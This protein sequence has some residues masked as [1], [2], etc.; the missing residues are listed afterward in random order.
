MTPTEQAARLVT[1]WR[2]YAKRFDAQAATETNLRQAIEL[3]AE[4][5][6][7]RA[8]AQQAEWFVIGVEAE[9]VAPVRHL[10]IVRSANDR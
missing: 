2:E 10:R 4:A 6:A 1:V 8:C 9:R 7:Y 5:R 3:R